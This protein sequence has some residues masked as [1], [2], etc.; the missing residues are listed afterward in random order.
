M[1]V[2]LL[3]MLLGVLIGILVPYQLPT[4][5][6]KYVSVS[7]LA[8]LDSVL[9]GTRAGLENKFNFSVFASGFFSNLLLAA[10]LTWIGDRLGVEIYQAAIVTFG[11]RIFQNLGY[12]R[13]DLLAQPPG[14]RSPLEDLVSKH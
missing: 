1:L 13:R 6:A 11:M 12:I 10:L 4:L 8:G 3:G 7:F 5:T 14:E 2:I 9:G